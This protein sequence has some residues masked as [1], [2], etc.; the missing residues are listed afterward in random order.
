MLYILKKYALQAGLDPDLVSPHVLRHTM[1]TRYLNANPG[2]LR[3][4]AAILGHTDLKT[5]M[6]YTEPTT[7]D[8]AARMARAEAGVSLDK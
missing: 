8:L 3:G 2:D 5:V 6:I 7:E 1:A 4:L